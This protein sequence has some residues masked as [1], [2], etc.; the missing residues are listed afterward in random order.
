MS[1]V[2]KAYTIRYEETS[3]KTI[4]TH[5]RIDKE[6]EERRSQ[7]K[8]AALPLADGEFVE[9]IKAVVIDQGPTK[10]EI[11]EKAALL[12]E[13]AKNEANHILDHAR[14]EAEK[15]KSEAYSEGQKKGYGDGLLQSQNEMNKLKSDYDEKSRHLKREYDEMATSLEPQMAEI[16]A[17]LVEKIT[18]I[19]I[20]DKEE[21]ILY[22]VDKTLKNIDKCDEYTI[23]VSKED[24]EYISMRKNLLLGAIGREVPMY[25]VEDSS[26]KKN[27]CFVETELKVINC[28]LDVQLN[29]LIMDLKLIAGI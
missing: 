13:E 11:A 29:N 15:M 23:K 19:V 6:L 12:L 28:S 5:M 10:E 4:D 3:K 18:G 17:V 1:N 16:I 7:I 14:K 21:V 8:I 27:Q 26:L 24:F 9:G 2:I 20:E 22:L 25:I